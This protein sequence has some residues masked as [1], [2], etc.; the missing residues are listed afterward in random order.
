MGSIFTLYLTGRALS[1][2][3]FYL[4]FF[5]FFS[6]LFLFFYQYFFWQTLKIHRIAGKGEGIII[7]LVSHFHPF[8]NVQ[9]VLQARFLPLLFYRSACNYQTDSW[10]GL[11]L[12]RDLPFIFIF[13]DAIKSELLT[14]TFQSGIMASESISKYHPCYFK[15]NQ[16]RL[17]PL[18]TTV[19]LSHLISTT[20]SHCLFSIRLRNL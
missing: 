17:T 1:W 15:V 16:L 6:F 18:D 20:P 13:I 12:L 9:L 3:L 14:L 4:Y 10:S 7:F 2:F 19:F 8:I 11:L 5:L